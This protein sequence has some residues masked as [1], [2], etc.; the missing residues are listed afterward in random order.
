MASQNLPFWWMMRAALIKGILKIVMARDEVMLPTLSLLDRLHIC[1]TELE[2]FRAKCEQVSTLKGESLKKK[3]KGSLSK[4][5][6]G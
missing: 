4:L 3:S 6:C 5:I 1:P 2:S